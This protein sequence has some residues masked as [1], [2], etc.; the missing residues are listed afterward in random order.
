MNDNPGVRK[1][2][3]HGCSEPMRPE[4]A[5]LGDDARKYFVK[6]GAEIDTLL[7]N[8]ME[9]SGDIGAV[10]RWWASSDP[11]WPLVPKTVV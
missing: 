7:G 2:D 4:D 5:E 6:H 10:L 11:M 1:C 8:G 3:F 9:T